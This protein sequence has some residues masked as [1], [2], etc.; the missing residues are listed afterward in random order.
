MNAI[1][2]N[3]GSHCIKNLAAKL[4]MT[5]KMDKT[6]HKTVIGTNPAMLAIKIAIRSKDLGPLK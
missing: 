3:Q 2:Q 6:H 1:N 4:H 5:I